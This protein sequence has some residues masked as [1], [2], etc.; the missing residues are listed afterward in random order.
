M[1]SSER[2]SKKALSLL[3]QPTRRGTPK[4]TPSFQGTGGLR[5]CP[6]RQIAGENAG[7]DVI[8]MTGHATVDTAVEAMKNGAYD[9]IT[10]P[11]QVDDLVACVNRLAERR[12]LT[13]DNRV[14]RR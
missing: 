11:F 12:D 5:I 9:Y 4:S 10:K 3:C 2:P 13:A 14:L 1:F 6:L 7:I 8:F